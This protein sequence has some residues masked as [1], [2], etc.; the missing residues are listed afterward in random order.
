MAVADGLPLE[1]TSVVLRDAVGLVVTARVHA[2][3]AHVT[4][5]WGKKPSI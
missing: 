4:G 1:I 3:C 2:V 5:N